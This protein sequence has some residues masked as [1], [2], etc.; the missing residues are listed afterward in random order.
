[1]L[2]VFRWRI[3]I[4]VRLEPEYAITRNLALHAL[5]FIRNR[6]ALPHSPDSATTL[7]ESKTAPPVRPA[8]FRN[9]RLDSD[10]SFIEPT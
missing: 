2:P 3:Q 4:R 5:A 6:I 8:A 7:D 10:N 9:R 1:M